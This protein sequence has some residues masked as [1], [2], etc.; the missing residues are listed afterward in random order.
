MYDIL[1]VICLYTTGDKVKYCIYECEN[2][3]LK[4]LGSHASIFLLKK[5]FICYITVDYTSGFSIGRYEWMLIP[6]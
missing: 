3:C 6:N 5:K 4:D 2:A 1:L